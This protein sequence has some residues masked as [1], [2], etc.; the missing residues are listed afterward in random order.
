MMGRMYAFSWRFE[1]GVNRVKKQL[2]IT[3]VVGWKRT[4]PAQNKSTQ[5]E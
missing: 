2:R 5:E 4:A 3:S 1:D